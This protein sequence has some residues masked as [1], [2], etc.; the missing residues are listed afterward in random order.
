MLLLQEHPFPEACK[1]SLCQLVFSHVPWRIALLTSVALGGTHLDLD[2][3][4]LQL[5]YRS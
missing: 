3:G 5:P 4:V 2:S 1:I